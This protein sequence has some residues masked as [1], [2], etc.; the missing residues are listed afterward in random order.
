MIVKP[1]YKGFIC[2]TAHPTGCRKNVEDM[3]AKAGKIRADGGK[4]PKNVVIIGAS[5]GYGLASR[6]VAAFAYKARTVGV[7]FEKEATEKHTAT[8]GFYNNRAFDAL[9]EKNGIPHRTLNGDAFTDEMKSEVVAACRDLF[10]GEKID[11]LVYSLAAPK[12]RH[13]AT[14]AL[15]SSVIKPVDEPYDSKTVDFHTGIVSRV[16]IQPAGET[17]IADTVKVMGGE[18]WQ[19]W[20]DRLI[21]ENLVA[22]GF[23]T[24]AYSYIGSS[25]THA[26]YRDG[27]IGK[28][29]DDLLARCEAIEETLKPFHGNAYVS[30]NKALVTQAS[31]AIPVVPLYVSLL[32][33]VMKRKG[34][35]EDCFD[36][37]ARLFTDRLYG[38]DH[39]VFD[40]QGRIRM[41]DLEMRADV[42]AE[43]DKFWPLIDSG[44]V[45]ELT[46]LEGYRKEF[47]GL[48]GFGRD[49]VDYDQDVNI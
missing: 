32:Y 8:A 13:P 39:D 44:N 26:I 25:I 48:F 36:Q 15:H 2:T 49:D 3:A 24:V 23:L 43:V 10:G 35:Q 47:F 27:T 12:R 1:K 31:S 20:V 7:S 21:A 46:D 41:D 19:M 45:M 42:Q 30:V 9:A 17:E 34:L 33:K 6:I 22:D 4:H 28:A 40:D 37:I 11:L 18:D 14:Q 29:K 5:G 16:T 38:P